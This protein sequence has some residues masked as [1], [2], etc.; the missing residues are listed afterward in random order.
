MSDRE[1]GFYWVKTGVGWECAK[2]AP[3]WW[4]GEVGEWWIDGDYDDGLDIVEIGPRIPAPNAP[5]PIGTRYRDESGEVVAV[6]APAEATADIIDELTIG[7][8]LPASAKWRSA[9]ATL[10]EL[11]DCWCETCRPVTLGDMRMVV[12]PECGNKRC[13]RATNHN[14]ACTGS[15][16]PGQEGA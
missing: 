2:W 3:T 8:I 16:E 11:P 6:V 12:C 14:N 13:P 9:L 4:D 10:P 7:K 1:D 5:P 15:N